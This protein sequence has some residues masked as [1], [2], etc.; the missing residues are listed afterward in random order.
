MTD[1]ETSR[2]VKHHIASAILALSFH[3]RLGEFSINE[4]LDS[5]AKAQKWLE[6]AKEKE[7]Q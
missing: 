1:N 2:A 6:E 3:S 7:K 5:L 4:A